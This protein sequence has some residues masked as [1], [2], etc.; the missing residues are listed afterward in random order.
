MA[1]EPIEPVVEPTVEPTPPA[2]P[3]PT[4]PVIAAEPKV[5]PTDP[6]A[7]PIPPVAPVVA[8]EPEPTEPVVKAEPDTTVEPTEEVDDRVIPQVGEYEL[9]EGVPESVAQF[10]FD[11]DMTQDQLNKTL[12]EFAGYVQGNE[13]AQKAVVRQQGD[14]LVKSWGKQKEGNLS[15]VQRALAQND[16]DGKL[17]EVLNETGFGNHPEVL[18]FFLRVGNSMRE[19]GFLK[20]A[21]NS[22]H[23]TGTSAALA[24]FGDNHPSSN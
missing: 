2:D 18:N 21:N 16:P 4:E 12:G 19:G 24:M 13:K 11:N 20:G 3:A 23:Q 5:T 6:P 14:E 9:P 10:A 1:K 22:P 8:A 15:L 7:D 17:T